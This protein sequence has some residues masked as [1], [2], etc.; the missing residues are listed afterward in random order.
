MKIRVLFL[1]FEVAGYFANY[2]L[3]ENYL[4]NNYNRFIFE[5]QN[6]AELKQTLTGYINMSQKEMPKR[7]SDRMCW[8]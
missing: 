2:V 6:K 7:D 1:F 3:T 5:S 4:I 8:L